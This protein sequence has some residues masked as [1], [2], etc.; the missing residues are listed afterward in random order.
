MPR[1][2][3]NIDQSLLPSLQN[4]IQSAYR[5]DFCV[6]YF[7]LRG[8]RHIAQAF[9]NWDG[10]IGK[11]CRVLVGMQR[12]PQDE[13]R[14]AFRVTPDNDIDNQ[15][16]LRLK[17]QL[18]EDFRKQLTIG[19][20]TNADEA[21]LRHLAEQLKT[22]KVIVKLYLQ[23][24]LHAKLY[25]LFRNDSEA[26]IVGYVGSS[27][28]TFSGL[29]QQGE[30]NVHIPEEDAG[31]KLQQWFDDRWDNRWCIDISQELIQVIE[32]S[33]AREQ[34]ISP[35]HIY[36]KMAYH[37]A[38]EARTG[39]SEFTI[40][41]DFS[42]TLFP[43]QQAAIQIA[44]H[45]LNKRG[46]VLLGDV[47]GLGKT[48]MATTLARIFV[49]D[50][51][52][53]TLILCPVNLV[54]MWEDYAANY[55]L[56]AKVL[57]ISQFIR[58][59]P[60]LRRY[61]LLIIDE[62]HNLRNR[63]GQRYRAIQE[64]IH[65]NECRVI[66]LS[67][68]PYNKSYLD[69]A[70]QLRL[71]VPEDQELTIKP[72]RLLRDIGESEFIRRYQTSPRTL[73]AF[74]KSDYA[75]DWRDLMRLYLVRRTRSFIQQNYAEI[76]PQTQRRYLS[77]PDGRRSYFPTRVPRTVT[78]AIDDQN[79]NDQ[80]ARLFSPSVVDSINDLTLPR[81]GLAGYVAATAEHSANAEQKRILTNL[82][83]AGK[84]LMGF[85]R[86]NLFKR[87]ESSGQVFLQSLERHILRNFIVLHALEN[88]K[89]VPIGTQDA[90][91]LDTRMSDV[92]VDATIGTQSPPQAGLYSATEAEFKQAATTTY[93]QYE[94][95]MANR[96]AWLP[97]S[98]FTEQLKGDLLNDAQ[99]LIKIL[100]HAG[101]WDVNK[102]TKLEALQ[103]LIEDSHPNE[104]ILV[105][106][107]FAD[108][109]G[110]VTEQLQ[111]LLP[112][113][114]IEGVTGQ[115]EELTNLVWRF[116]PRSNGKSYAPEQEIRVLIATDVLSE[117]Q[118]LQDAHIVVNYDLPWAIIRL[119]QRAGRVDRIGQ[120]AD[121]ILSYTFL[122]ADGVERII[123]LRER[124]R[125]RLQQNAEVIGTDEAFF[126]DDK[127][128][129]AM[130]DL[131]TEQSG[132][133]DGDADTEVDLASYAYQIWKNAVDADPSL[134]HI[135]PNM[136]PVVYATRAYTPT[137]QMPEGVL[138]YM[139]NRDGN[140]ALAWIDTAKNSV[141]ESQL[142]ILNA[143]ACHPNTAP[144]ERM[145]DHHDLVHA[146][147]EFLAE[148]ERTGGH[149]GRPS[150][151][152]ARTYAQLKRYVD[153]IRGT[154]FDMPELHNAVADLYR[155]PLHQ[156]AANT[157]NRQLRSGISDET[158][159][160]L[161]VGFYEEHRLCLIHQET[162]EDQE[163]QIIC[164]LG[165]KPTTE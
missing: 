146:G 101:V 134:Q 34:L 44:A 28:L 49:D 72:E 135:I 10:G 35:Y 20:P 52:L 43:F 132:I 73:A 138:V 13:I 143:A 87:L 157:L 67:A 29:V 30:L 16:V 100:H 55:R 19:T 26:P 131:F 141:T 127:D 102:D 116:S 25:L 139:R 105:F 109:V 144:Q 39:V 12:A 74:E 82:S 114:A 33:W 79:P 96:F 91:L 31:K 71:F 17:K 145:D 130:R 115:T 152:R 148:Q 54:K 92:D 56:H 159:A 47:V 21:G 93:Q 125:H 137:P 151:V 32:E 84:R 149:L 150:G 1:I 60:T 156:T 6:G 77:Y 70:N 64:Y 164:S 48:L 63:E 14:A 104:K 123:N 126:E 57:P 58:E 81:Y 153:Q 15:T 90:A 65:T 78:F 83:R 88:D 154:L 8:W 120:Q 69:L 147:M 117:G 37:L 107:Q 95:E 42:N 11:C 23:H 76:D 98:F 112:T 68:T 62:S 111:R 80:Y 106:T 108:T 24:P 61:R 53:E 89:P 75:D 113:I 7:N 41:S 160:Q 27:N 118:N 119:I 163:P 158:L 128:T 9:D 161:V 85:C 122:P 121:E 124:I 46:G 155:Y 5:A 142:T 99:A 18:A 110:Y 97:A 40:P 140:D 3:D 4:T 86:T 36:I 162:S 22:Q 59:L 136:P 129:K 38:Q 66:L 133:L 165:L 2:L 94:T 51:F 45:H 50:Y 103:K